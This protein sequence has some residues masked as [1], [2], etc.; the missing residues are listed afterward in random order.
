MNTLAVDE[1]GPLWLLLE[2]FFEWLGVWGR[3]ALAL[4]FLLALLFV[5]VLL[6]RRKS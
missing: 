1:A 4:G 5:I 6:V 2:S 3:S